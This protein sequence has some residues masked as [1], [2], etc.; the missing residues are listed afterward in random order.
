[1]KA[2]AIAAAMICTAGTAAANDLTVT[3]DQSKVVQLASPAST[4]VVG[5]PEI[6][7]ITMQDGDTAF[8]TGKAFGTTNVIAMDSNGRQIASFR[9]SVTGTGDRT[10]TLMRGGQRVTLSCAPRCEQFGEAVGEVGMSAPPA[11]SAAAPA[12]APPVEVNMN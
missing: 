12:A 6:A 1:M 2:I 3:K 8:V 10:V 5:N 9:V 7:D 4:I 11:P